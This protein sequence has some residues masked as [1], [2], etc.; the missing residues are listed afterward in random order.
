[1]NFYI[2]K[3][4]PEREKESVT[5]GKSITCK[6]EQGTRKVTEKNIIICK[7]LHIIK[8]VMPFCFTLVIIIVCCNILKNYEDFLVKKVYEKKIILKLQ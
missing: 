4:N 2:Y 1:M 6:Q 5:S 7:M 3:P 8:K